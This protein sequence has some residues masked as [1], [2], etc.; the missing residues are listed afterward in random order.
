MATSCCRISLAYHCLEIHNVAVI[1]SACTSR[2]VPSKEYCHVVIDGSKWKVGTRR[3]TWASGDRDG[4]HACS[5][6]QNQQL[7]L[8]SGCLVCAQNRAR[9]SSCETW[10]H[11]ILF[12]HARANTCLI[13]QLRPDQLNFWL[14]SFA[15]HRFGKHVTLCTWWCLYTSSSVVQPTQ[16]ISTASMD[17]LEPFPIC[18]CSEHWQPNDYVMK[19]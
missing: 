15:S 12:Q 14:L 13:I 3:G 2:L 1:D 6:V 11:I 9:P 17:R 19:W 18:Y 10:L 7:A 5:K 4:P 16:Y 8:L